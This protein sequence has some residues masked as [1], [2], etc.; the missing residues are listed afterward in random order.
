M[1]KRRRRKKNP[2]PGE[3]CV[4]LYS[5]HFWE[6]YTDS[7][8]F[9]LFFCCCPEH[10]LQLGGRWSE[11]RDCPQEKKLLSATDRVGQASVSSL[12]RKSDMCFCKKSPPARTQTDT[13]THERTHAQVPLNPHSSSSHRIT[14]PTPQPPTTSPPPLPM[15][16]ACP[17]SPIGRSHRDGVHM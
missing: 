6:N 1:S 12:A 17:P 3:I 14:P 16:R 11:K 5:G 2:P 9:V 4:G 10:L 7:F 15:F 13:H 8:I